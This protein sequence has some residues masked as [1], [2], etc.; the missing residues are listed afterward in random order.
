MVSESDES[1]Q[2][3]SDMGGERSSYSR[4]AANNKDD[5]DYSQKRGRNRTSSSSQNSG[6]QSKPKT[7]VK[8]KTPADVA[9]ANETSL[10]KAKVDAGYLRGSN[11]HPLR[12]CKEI[13]AAIMEQEYAQPFLAPVDAEALGLDDYYERVKEPMD[14][15][16]IW[17]R[18]ESGHY[19][20]AQQVR[21]DVTKVWANCLTY[22]GS[23][24]DIYEQALDLS[25]QFDKQ[26]EASISPPQHMGLRIFPQGQEWVG[27]DL[28]VYWDGDHAWFKARV[29]GYLGET[30]KGHQYR[31]QY[32]EDQETE[33]VTLP[34][35]NI[36]ML[37]LQPLRH[38]GLEML[39]AWSGEG[40]TGKK[41]P[42]PK[43]LPFIGVPQ[44][45]GGS[46][47][48]GGA[49]AANGASAAAA[50]DC[51]DAKR[52][53]N[54]K[55]TGLKA[56]VLTTEEKGIFIGDDGIPCTP[57]CHCKLLLWC[58][59][60]ARKGLSAVPGSVLAGA[61][62]SFKLAQARGRQRCSYSLCRQQNSSTRFHVITAST[63]AGGRDWTDLAGQTLCSCCFQQFRNKGTLVRARDVV[64]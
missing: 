18:L 49:K 42:P 61:K 3:S 35:I 13:L 1:Y 38:P 5:P 24:H 26:F 22:N 54:G 30:Q 4:P 12:R 46:R 34:D 43:M 19:K 16:T 55:Q 40:G 39:P 17:S 37:D 33:L 51:G 41:G 45:R 53:E 10:K 15:G 32:P 7:A 50:G 58:R 25:K 20:S 47:G 48:W 56:S 52:V 8:R 62:E 6:K 9:A 63:N 31:I 36:A 14:L 2:S 27:T 59:F 21:E 60:K 23:D 57:V 11:Q 29:V 44:N 28:L 64:Q